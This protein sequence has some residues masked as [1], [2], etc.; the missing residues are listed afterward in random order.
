MLPSAAKRNIHTYNPGARRAYVA[1]KLSVRCRQR[2]Q[3]ALGSDTSRSRTVLDYLRG[4]APR[5]SPEQRASIR[6]RETPLGDIVDSQP[7]YVGDPDAN[8]FNG[9]TFTGS[10]SYA[11]FASNQFR[12][13]RRSTWL[14]T[15]A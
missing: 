4:D 5:S 3:T 11:T 14:P 8:L 1:F 12:A 10:D 15:T 2:E 7:V 6:N 9:Q 13:R